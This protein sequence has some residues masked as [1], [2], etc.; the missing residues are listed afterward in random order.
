MPDDFALLSYNL[1]VQETESGLEKIPSV[2]GRPES[3]DAWRHV[4]MFEFVR[5]IFDAFKNA[6]W[7]TI[8]DSGGD[9]HYLKSIG[10]NN[11]VSSSI[12]S[13][14]LNQLSRL[15]HLNG[16]EIQEINAENISKPNN[17]VDIIFCKEAYH[18]F[19][20]PP[21]AFYEFLRVC[22]DMAVFI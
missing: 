3:V 5:P 21:V 10:I 19:P 13:T 1:H 22:R 17:S 12:S 8:G 9:A 6:S 20:R 7:L 15:G 4:R 11:L 2:I 18:H 16:V 14:K